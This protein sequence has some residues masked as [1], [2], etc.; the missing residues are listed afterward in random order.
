MR[1][2]EPIFVFGLLGLLG[3]LLTGAAGC[4]NTPSTPNNNLPPGTQPAP[5]K[6]EAGAN[7]AADNDC[8]PGLGCLFPATAC[9]ALAVCV[10]APPTP[11]D[12][13]Q[14][15]CSC[16]GEPIQVCDGY[17]LSPVDPTGTC[18]GGTVVVPDGGADATIPPADAAPDSA[19]VPDAAKTPDASDAG[20]SDAAG[21]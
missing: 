2:L 1:R 15:A 11:C 6:F 3:F 19:V 10:T 13:P 18:D 9:N 16:L 12:H 14:N 7:C 17:A 20:A 8:E 4:S 21:D 5:T